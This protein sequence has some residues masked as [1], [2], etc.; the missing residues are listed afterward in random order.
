MDIL[1]LIVGGLVLT[2]AIL[3][4]IKVMVRRFIVRKAQAA[5][6]TP[7]DTLL[8]SLQPGKPAIIYFTSPGCGPCKLVQR[9]ALDQVAAAMRDGVQILT[10]D[11]TEQMD[12]ALR[13][14]VMKVPRT[15]ILDHNQHVYASNLDVTHANV[16]QK[17]LAEA[18]TNA[19]NPQPMKLI[20][21]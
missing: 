21:A 13:W 20:Q 12:A 10:V 14:G 4:G 1:L 8:D 19:S 16:L 11:I 6:M 2:I 7:C 9:P 17:Q 15:F 3:W 5:Q 18:E